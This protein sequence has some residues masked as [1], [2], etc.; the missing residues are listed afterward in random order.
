MPNIFTIWT[1]YRQSWLTPDLR[2]Q[3]HI[4]PS[5]VVP[6]I[7]SQFCTASKERHQQTA[8]LLKIFSRTYS[9]QSLEMVQCFP[10]GVKVEHIY[11]KTLIKGWDLL[12]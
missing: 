10:S 4:L 8:L 2:A 6:H 12:C 5:P 7:L 1:H 3:C 11:Q 9:K